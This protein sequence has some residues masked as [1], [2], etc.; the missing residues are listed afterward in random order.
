[1]V[2]ELKKELNKL[3]EDESKDDSIQDVEEVKL[4]IREA[5]TAQQ[6]LNVLDRISKD[7]PKHREIYEYLM[8]ICTSK[9]G[10]FNGTIL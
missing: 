10:W 2:Q 9:L 3:V 6:I 1:M 4:E 8:R 5:Y 7:I